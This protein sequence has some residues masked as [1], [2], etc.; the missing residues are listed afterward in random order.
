MSNYKG[1][2]RSQAM[3]TS[4][5]RASG[6]SSFEVIDLL[7]V[8]RSRC[9]LSKVRTGATTNGHPCSFIVLRTLMQDARGDLDR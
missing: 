5:S 7:P 6:S 1:F 4:A 9:G 2:P 8:C 3:M